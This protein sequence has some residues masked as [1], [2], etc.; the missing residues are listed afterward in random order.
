MRKLM[1]YCEGCGGWHSPE[2]RQGLIRRMGQGKRTPMAGEVRARYGDHVWPRTVAGDR[3]LW[4]DLREVRGYLKD[5]AEG[6][7]QRLARFL[8]MVLEQGVCATRAATLLHMNLRRGSAA[9]EA[10]GYRYVNRGRWGENSGWF[11]RGRAA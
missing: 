4:R 3:M 11:R 10:K 2:E 5:T 8:E 1:A 9:L 6:A 7:P